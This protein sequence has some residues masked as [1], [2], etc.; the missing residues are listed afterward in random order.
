MVIERILFLKT[1]F[2]RIPLN[3]IECPFSRQGFI[4]MSV[5]AKGNHF[6]DQIVEQVHFRWFYIADVAK[7]IRAAVE[8]SLRDVVVQ[9][10]PEPRRHVPRAEIP[11]VPVSVF[12]EMMLDAKRKEA[13]LLLLIQSSNEAWVVG[14]T[15]TFKIFLRLLEI[16]VQTKSQ[17]THL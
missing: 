11:M 15:I 4:K 13:L 3:F 10:I 2:V 12:L 6:V 1:F 7:R 17:H 8:T 9:V 14:K 16:S 5:D